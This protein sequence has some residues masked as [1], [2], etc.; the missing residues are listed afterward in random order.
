LI[1]RY[2]L[3]VNRSWLVDWGRLVDRGRLIGR[4]IS[5]S[6]GRRGR[7]V[8]WGRSI[9]WS[10]SVGRGR[11]ISRCRGVS[12]S[13][14]IGRLAVS[15]VGSLASVD[16]IG[17][18]ATVGIIHLVVDGL[19][20]AV[21]KS[22]RVGAAGGIAITVL[23]SIELGAI[24]VIHSV[25]VGIDWRRIIGWLLVCR[26]GW[27]IGRSRGIAIL[28]SIVSHSQGSDSQNNASLNNIIIHKIE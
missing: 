4:S 1:C 23:T 10:R 3:G 17:N 14:G 21:R 5:R 27:S 26:V 15:R 28:G 16:N 19:G 24:V 9:S 6:I 8:G 11:G 7:L 12:R 18:V 25:V 22:H 20:P 2:L 13:R